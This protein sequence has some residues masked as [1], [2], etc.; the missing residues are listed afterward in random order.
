[1]ADWRENTYA[2]LICLFDYRN[3]VDHWILTPFSWENWEITRFAHSLGPSWKFIHTAVAK[4]LSG[5]PR[6]LIRKI[7]P[8]SYGIRAPARRLRSSYG[9]CRVKLE[10]DVLSDI[11]SE[12]LESKSGQ[13]HLSLSGFGL[14]ARRPRPSYERRGVTGP[15]AGA[16]PRRERGV[17][18]AG[19]A[20]QPT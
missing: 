13:T 8:L 19:G 1:M 5:S 17:T 10:P 6:V 18:A 7:V 16:H 9:T 15:N 2:I 20:E 12:S 4:V 11:W 3:G 14:L